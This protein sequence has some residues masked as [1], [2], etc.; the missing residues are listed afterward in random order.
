MIGLLVTNRIRESIG[1]RIIAAAASAGNEVDFVLLPADPAGRLPPDDLQ[2]IDVAFFSGDLYPDG[3]RGFFAA[4]QGAPRLQWL[5]TFNAGIDAPVFG[6]I[7][8][9][10]TRIT[11][12]SGSTA[13]PI[14]QTLVTALLMLARGFPEWL[15]S[16]RRREWEPRSGPPPPDLASQTLTVVGLGAIGTEIARLGQALGLHV[17][18]VRRTPVTGA[19]PIDEFITPDALDTV[20][21][22]TD[23][24]AL[25][26]PLTLATEHMI[27]DRRLTLLPPTACLLNVGR[28]SLVDE[29]A[30]IRS[31]SSG[32]LAGAYLDVFEEEPLPPDSPLWN[33]PNVIIT[34]HNSS[35]SAGNEARTWD[36]FIQNF[37]AWIHGQPLRNEV[38]P[39]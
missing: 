19:E 4:A 24:L 8:A 12:S 37:E 35:V 10:G 6:R 27:D 11:T 3:S 36:Y 23:W 33:F 14:A 29:S 30:L 7:M 9:N 39:G 18:G 22:R 31:L 21:P 2:R 5:H 17:V 28:G 1:D 13:V 32:R 26:A 15:Q 20:L 34:P 16:Q 25:A 38:Q